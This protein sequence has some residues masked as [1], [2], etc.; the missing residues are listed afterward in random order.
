MASVDW[1]EIGNVSGTGHL[2]KKSGTELIPVNYSL[3]VL[4][5]MERETTDS[6]PVHGPH[7]A[8]GKIEPIADP[9]F[10]LRNVSGHFTLYLEDGQRFD[11]M[12]AHGDG[13][14]VDSFG[15]GF[16]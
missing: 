16:Y 10:I 4:Q 7:K 1:L 13:T 9:G 8:T 2:R 12:I 11:V 6:A 5:K 15:G 14:I 3:R